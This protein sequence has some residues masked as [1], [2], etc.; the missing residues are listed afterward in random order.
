M[1]NNNFKNSILVVLFNYSNC[2]K[3]KDF[4]KKYL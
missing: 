3:N 4:I 2:I 1:N